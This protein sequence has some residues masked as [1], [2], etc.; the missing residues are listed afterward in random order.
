MFLTLKKMN[1]RVEA[2]TF[3]YTLI[4]LLVTWL[5]QDTVVLFCFFPSLELSVAIFSMKLV[6]K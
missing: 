5:G 3:I 6:L 1:V 4:E 2:K